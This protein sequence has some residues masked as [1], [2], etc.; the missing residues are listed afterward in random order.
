MIKV[1][2]HGAVTR[3]SHRRDSAQASNGVKIW[4]DPRPSLQG[5]HARVFLC[6]FRQSG[7]EKNLSYMLG[8][9]LRFTSAGDAELRRDGA[10]GSAHPGEP[11]TPPGGS[12]Q[13]FAA[14]TAFT[15][16]AGKSRATVSVDYSYVG[17]GQSKFQGEKLGNSDAQLVNASVAGA[18]ALDEKWFIPL[19]IS[20]ANLFLDPVAGAPI[21]EEIHT[22]RLLGG[23][24]YHLNDQWSFSASLGPAFYRLSDVDTSTLGLG[25]MVQAIWRMQPSLT[26][27]FGIGF[28]PDSDIPVLPAAGARWNI[29]TNLTLNLMFPRPV[30]IYRAAPRLSLFAGGDIKFAVFR[31]SSDEGDKIGQLPYNNAL[32]TYRDFHLEPGSS[33]KSCA[34]SH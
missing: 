9:N 16:I 26:L 32:G 1:A 22:L 19:G 2:S 5:L 31:A 17:P 6:N 34:G 7:Y 3:L 27:A 28:N 20:S 14:P 18:V 24:G 15:T 8:C 12:Q 30:L 13:D 4:V 25:G 21:P 33:A 11:P 23:L 10:G 29:R